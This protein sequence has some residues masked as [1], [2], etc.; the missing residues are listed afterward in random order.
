MSYGLCFGFVLYR[1][2]GETRCPD[3][4]ITWFQF[5]PMFYLLLRKRFMFQFM[6]RL[7][8]K[9]KCFTEAKCFTNRQKCCFLTYE[10]ILECARAEM[11]VCYFSIIT[12][13]YQS[14]RCALRVINAAFAQFT[15]SFSSSFSGLA[16]SSE[17]LT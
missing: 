7:T 9:Q 2:P 13:F 15:R 17:S 6:F 5:S 12:I 14:T 4:C 1:Q 3:S 11:F 16:F 10:S 8:Y